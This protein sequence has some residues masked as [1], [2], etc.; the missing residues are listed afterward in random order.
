MAIDIF[1]D[2]PEQAAFEA[3]SVEVFQTPEVQEQLNAARKLFAADPLAQT[4]SGRATLERFGE[5][6]RARCAGLD[7]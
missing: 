6:D 1:V 2:D 5:R 7:R 4:P 3:K